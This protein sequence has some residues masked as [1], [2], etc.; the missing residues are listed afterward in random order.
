MLNGVDLTMS[1]MRL[2]KQAGGSHG[3]IERT[4]VALEGIREELHTLNQLWAST[5]AST[6][7][8]TEGVSTEAAEEGGAKVDDIF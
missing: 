1:A 8:T 3:Q 5:M 6:G 4:V 2:M 7:A